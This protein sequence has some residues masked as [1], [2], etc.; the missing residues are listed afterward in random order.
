MS[1]W[2]LDYGDWEGPEDDIPSVFYT[3]IPDIGDVISYSFPGDEPIFYLVHDVTSENVLLRHCSETG[4][5]YNDGVIVEIKTENWATWADQYQIILEDKLPEIEPTGD[6]W[7][8][9]IPWGEAEQDYYRTAEVMPNGADLGFQTGDRVMLPHGG[10]T[11]TVIEVEEP[12]EEEDGTFTNWVRVKKDDDG[13][14]VVAA[15]WMLEFVEGLEGGMMPDTLPWSDEEQNYYR[16]AANWDEVVREKAGKGEFKPGATAIVTYAGGAYDLVVKRGDTVTLLETIDGQVWWVENERGEK[17][18]FP[19]MRMFVPPQ[20]PD[21]TGDLWPDIIP[22]G[23]EEQQYYRTAD[24]FLPPI[25]HHPDEFVSF[26]EYIMTWVDMNGK[27]YPPQRVRFIS[28]DGSRSL[29]GEYSGVKFRNIDQGNMLNIHWDY[30]VWMC[31]NGLFVPAPRKSEVPAP[32]EEA[33]DMMWP[34]TLPWDEA[35]QNYYRNAGL[36][37]WFKYRKDIQQADIQRMPWVWTPEGFYCGACGEGPWRSQALV[38]LHIESRHPKEKDLDEEWFG[39][40]KLTS[41]RRVARIK[42]MSYPVLHTMLAADPSAAVATDA[43]TAA[44]GQVYIVGGAVRDAVLGRNPKDV[45]LMVSGLTEDQITQALSPLGKLNFTGA[46][47]G[48]FRFR[49]GDNPEVEIALPRTERSTGPAYT[50]FEVT[51]DPFLPIDEDLRRRDFTGNAMAYAPVTQELIDPYG[52]ADDL[53]N[54]QLRLVNPD[55]FRDDPLRVVRALVANARFGLEPDDELMQ[56]LADNAHRIKNLPGE[57]IQMELDKLLSGTDPAEALRLAEESGI[58]DYLIPE[59]SSAVGFDQMNPHHDLDVFSHTLQVLRRMS[60]LSNDPD[61]RLAALLH[62]SGK[63]AS[64]WR[65]EDAPEGGGGHFYKK[66]DDDGTVRG[67]D[68]EVVGAELADAFMRRLRYPNERRE[69][70][71]N[72]IR[73]HMFPYF[74]SPKGARKLLA[75]L[76]GDV[77]TAFD[78]LKLRE[79]DASGKSTGSMSDFDSASLARARELLQQ[80]LSEES[81]TT[82]KDLAVNGHDMMQLGFEREEIGQKLRELLDAVVENPELNERDT[83]LELAQ[84][85]HA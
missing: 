39:D 1:D 31:E 36:R 48:V 5:P 41:W 79:A 81:A 15:D 74:D 58:I 46:Q 62:D 57:R 29:Y 51:T 28:F 54:S 34:D 25:P 32:D 10:G 66:I 37:D 12:V 24:T 9:T 83:L 42:K 17:F 77:N 53:G 22:W 23:E 73:N 44:G 21:P 76:G 63:P 49:E 82:V 35:E 68:H 75:S 4:V 8:D 27:E 55:A 19:R 64:F 78:L 67:D 56:A 52:G 50:D 7:P 40:N 72:L 85:S 26:Q 13:K 2:N 45:D 20:E 71:V 65:D 33:A 6:L 69:R 61:L 14:V 47:F 38:D 30:A 59:L 43:L 70:V 3:Q 60:D 84:S 18:Q 80:V 16:T 11:G